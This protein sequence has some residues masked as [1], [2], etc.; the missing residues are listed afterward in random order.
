[1][2][3][4]GTGGRRAGT[5]ADLPAWQ[6]G[7]CLP[8]ILH[9]LCGQHTT[10]VH[11]L[12]HWLLEQSRHVR[13]GGC[14]QVQCTGALLPQAKRGA[15]SVGLLRTMLTPRQGPSRGLKKSPLVVI[16]RG[17]AL[18]GAWSRVLWVPTTCLTVL[19][20]SMRHVHQ[21]EDAHT[22]SRR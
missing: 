2:A 18:V 13:Q 10:A 11:Q 8:H 1:M 12:C 5:D 14:G 19:C 15:W 3:G 6:A 4:P 16:H 21:G 17:S 20:L 22:S 9:Q 7:R